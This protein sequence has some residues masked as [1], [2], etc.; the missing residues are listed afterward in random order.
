MGEDIKQSG[1][2]QIRV[3]YAVFVLLT[4][5]KDDK[6]LS[7]MNATIRYLLSHYHQMNEPVLKEDK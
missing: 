7:S 2:Y 5:L 6:E 4:S 3:D 1:S